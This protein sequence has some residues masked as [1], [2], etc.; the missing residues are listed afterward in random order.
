MEPQR[1]ACACQ[2]PEEEFG[3]KADL[4]GFRDCVNFLAVWLW[5]SDLKFL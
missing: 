1:Q 4:R 2:V 5:A 3:N